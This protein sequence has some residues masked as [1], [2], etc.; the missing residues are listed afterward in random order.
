MG[1]GD[2]FKNMFNMTDDYGEDSEMEDEEVEEEQETKDVRSS[3]FSFNRTRTED[4][5]KVVDIR[6]SGPSASNGTSK[7]KVDLCEIECFE[8]VSEIGARINEKRIVLISLEKCPS[9][10]KQRV[11][12]VLS[13]ISF[14]NG[15]PV[16]PFAANVYV[17]APY[18]VDVST[19]MFSGQGNTRF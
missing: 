8:D 9:D 1:F 19:D 3:G 15:S 17:V 13:G 6:S 16:I 2:K 5:S 10:I 4:D 14:A 12:D 7:P 11:F 18:N